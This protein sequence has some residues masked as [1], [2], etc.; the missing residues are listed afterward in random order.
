M[1]P[2]VHRPWRFPHHLLL[3]VTIATA[4]AAEPALEFSGMITSAGVRTFQFRDRA[5][6]TSRWIAIGGQCGGFV[7]TSYDEA[8]ETVVLTKGDQVLR[9]ALVAG[10]V[11]DG[12]SSA[13]L[14]PAQASAIFTNLQ[15]LWALADQYYLATKKKQATFAELVGPGWTYGGRVP[16]KSI[17]GED[18]SGLMFDQNRPFFSVTAAS[19]EKI[20]L[21]Q[22]HRGAANESSF[23][24]INPGDTGMKVAVIYGLTIGDLAARNEGVEFSRLKVGQ[25]LRVH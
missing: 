12:A 9:L 6:G 7:L 8:H 14:T 3:L 17:A 10:K 18:Y 21:D 25:L 13:S 24:S 5:E 2:R 15:Q 20:T 19:G 1:S 11:R 16:V 4:F 22:L 23:H